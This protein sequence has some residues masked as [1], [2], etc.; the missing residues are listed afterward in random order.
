MQLKK[1]EV[2]KPILYA[3]KVNYTKG[4]SELR[5]TGTK[6]LRKLKRMPGLLRLTVAE[7]RTSVSP[8]GKK[9]QQQG[10]RG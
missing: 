6:H 1:K 7:V 9:N 10:A 2:T 8:V 5:V 3:Y 4:V